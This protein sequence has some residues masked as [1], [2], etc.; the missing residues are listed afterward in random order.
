MPNITKVSNSLS[1]KQKNEILNLVEK[2]AESISINVFQKG[3]KIYDYLK[4]RELV[5]TELYLLRIGDAEPRATHLIIATNELNNIIG[6]IL[7]HKVLNQPDDIAIINT[8]VESGFRKQGVFRN[9]LQLL[10]NEYKSISLSCFP[11]LVEFYKKLDFKIQCQWETQ[12]GMYYGYSDDGQIVTI[13]D[14]DLNN[15]SK[16]IEQFN[17]FKKKNTD[18]KKILEKLNKDNNEAIIKAE[19]F[20]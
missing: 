9:M 8:V 3:S 17:L 6:Y 2:N 10:K 5:K 19:K 20:I 14:N 12:I 15:K 7:Y 18:W 16:I 4:V 11:E 1:D 13:D